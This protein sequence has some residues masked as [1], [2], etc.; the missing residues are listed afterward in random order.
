MTPSYVN[1]K[2][3]FRLEQTTSRTAHRS[4][5]STAPLEK[6]SI[7]RLPGVHCHTRFL[8]PPDRVLDGKTSVFQSLSPPHSLQALSPSPLQRI[9]FV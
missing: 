1:K 3:S 2:E 8:V 4:I 9:F 5:H 6:R 7:L